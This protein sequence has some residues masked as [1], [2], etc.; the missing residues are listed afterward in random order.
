MTPA[1]KHS[2]ALIA[3]PFFFHK[4][5]SVLALQNIGNAWEWPD[6]GNFSSKQMITSSRLYEPAAGQM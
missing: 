3:L 6:T 2:A 5:I 1:S 4:S